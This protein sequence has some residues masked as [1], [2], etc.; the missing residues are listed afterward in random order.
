MELFHIIIKEIKR[1]LGFTRVHK[2]WS[3]KSAVILSH[4]E[5]ERTW[6]TPRVAVLFCLKMMWQV[7]EYWGKY[8]EPYNC[9]INN[10]PATVIPPSIPMLN[11]QV[12]S[13]SL[14][15][16]TECCEPYSIKKLRSC[17]HS[18]LMSKVWVRTSSF[19]ALIIQFTRYWMLATKTNHITSL[20]S[21]I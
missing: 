9:V 19:K 10:I 7:R 12:F 18:K 14:W 13:F 16:D 2:N 4:G 17:N 11:V 21:N 1:P 3:L 15:F 8:P 5:N 6:E 20:P